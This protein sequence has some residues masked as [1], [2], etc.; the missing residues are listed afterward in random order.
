MALS[1]KLGL[2]TVQFGLSYGISNTG[3]QTSKEEVRRI[4]DLAL[5]NNIT[6]LDTASA[7]GNAETVLGENGV[8]DFTVV[9]KFMTPK[10]GENIAAQLNST[11]RQTGTS[12]LYGYLA[13]RPEDLLEKPHLWEQLQSFKEQQLVKK[14]G[15]SLNK[16]TELE[17]LL[18]KGYIPDL[19]QVPFNY[20]DNRFENLMTEL[21]DKGCEIHTRSAF[22][23][24]LFFKDAATLPDFFDG[25]KPIIASVQN[26]ES[27]SGSLLKY[28]LE[29]PFIDKVIIGVE[30]A[31]QLQQNLDAI[32]SG[33]ALPIIDVEISENILMPANWPKA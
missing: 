13:H 31:R 7:Y 29:K 26:N 33:S 23:Q 28:V 5:K 1:E 6:T 16:P 24:G 4:L 11:L 27:V 20:L 22:L 19:I 8:D 21:K 25:V 18:D 15:F 3:G 12:R 14:T 2:G 9:S 30:D 32:D 10:E 17:R